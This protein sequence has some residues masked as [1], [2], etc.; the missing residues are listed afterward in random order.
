[1]NPKNI[2]AMTLRSGKEVQESEPMIL[3]DKDEEKIENEL[4][5]EGS[6]G[7]NSVV[8]PDPIVEVKT[9]LPPFPSRLEK[10]RNRIRKRRF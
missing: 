6:N 7:K 3:K 2:S 1:M 5:K 8:L 4:E 9:H 10:P